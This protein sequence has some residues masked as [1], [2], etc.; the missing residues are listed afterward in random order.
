MVSFELLSC[1]FCC[2]FCCDFAVNIISRVWGN[3]F[4]CFVC[5]CVFA[6]QITIANFLVHF[7]VAK[8]LVLVFRLSEFYVVF[9]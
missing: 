4:S 7:F 5:F 6:L 3:F 2:A 9:F 8:L 1:C